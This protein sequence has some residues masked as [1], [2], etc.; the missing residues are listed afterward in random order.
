MTECKFIL[1]EPRR[2]TEVARRPSHRCVLVFFRRGARADQWLV[3]GDC[4]MRGQMPRGQGAEFGEWCQRWADGG[5][6]KLLAC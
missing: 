3:G 4:L 1:E 6:H 5:V 2:M